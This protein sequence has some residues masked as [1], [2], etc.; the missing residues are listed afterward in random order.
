MVCM[1]VVVLAFNMGECTGGHE[2]AQLV[3]NTDGHGWGQVVD[4]DG[5]KC[6]YW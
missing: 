1:R 5:L 6:W 2:W 3:M 4:A